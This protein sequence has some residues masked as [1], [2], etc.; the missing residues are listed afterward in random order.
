M[1]IIKNRI[2]NPRRYLY[3]LSTDEAFYIAA[4]LSAEDIENLKFYGIE[5]DSPAR[6]PV[7]RKSATYRNANGHWLLDKTLPKEE[8]WFTH[9][10]HVIDWHGEHHYG[11]CFQRRMCY[12]RHLVPPTELAFVIEDGVL[13]SPLM[14]NAEENMSEVKAAMNI[15]LEMLGHCEIWTADRVP[16]LPPV[17]QQ[18][19][20]WEILRAGTR[21]KDT[22]ENYI[23]EIIS[24]RPRGHQ[25]E[26]KSRHEHL[27][28]R[29]PEFCVLG[30]QN[31]WGYV[32]YGFPA[33]N[34][35][36]FEAN[37][38]NNATYVFRGDW[39]TASALTKMEVLSGNLQE[40]RIYHTEQWRDNLG[41]LF[42]RISQEVA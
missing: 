40:A 4:A 37:E 14:K 35:Y 13:L 10:Y 32:V 15:M 27:W 38:I 36:I 6:V 25:E 11:T 34:L 21:E 24:R 12:Q 26:I 41:R 22:W 2:I 23:E 1:K 19:V 31:F 33:M 29:S 28:N 9:P 17:K 3:A 20:P 7:P 16:A 42:C 8:R 18:E 30:T 39:E 5:L